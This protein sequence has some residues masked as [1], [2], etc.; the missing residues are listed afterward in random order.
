MFLPREKVIILQHHWEF[1]L[2]KRLCCFVRRHKE[3]TGEQRATLRSD[4]DGKVER[5]EVKVIRGGSGTIPFFNIE[6]FRTPIEKNLTQSTS[7]KTPVT[8]SK[9]EKK[10]LQYYAGR[11]GFRGAPSIHVS[12]YK[13]IGL[14]RERYPQWRWEVSDEDKFNAS[15]AETLKIEKA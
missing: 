2:L 6:H 11:L 13:C 10:A 14:I 9:K 7:L 5:D 3:A 8:M 1:M 12:T 4:P 15:V